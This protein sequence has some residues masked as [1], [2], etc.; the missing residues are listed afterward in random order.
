MRKVSKYIPKR[1][2][3]S[4]FRKLSAL[5]DGSRRSSGSAFQGT[6]NGECPMAEHAVM[7]SWYDE[8]VAAGRLKSLMTGNVRCG[9]A[10]VHEVL[11]SLVLETPVNCHS[12]LMEDSL[13]NIEPVQLGVEQMMVKI[14]HHYVLQANDKT[15]QVAPQQQTSTWRTI[16]GMDRLTDRQTH[17]VCAAKRYPPTSSNC[18]WI[19]KIHHHYV[20]QANDKTLQVAPQQ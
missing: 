10:A 13:R 14:H 12:K 1:C 9:V 19:I 8:M 7:M 2:V 11:E 18:E 20:L 5:S 16:S 17:S 6:G 4:V 3:F 15:L